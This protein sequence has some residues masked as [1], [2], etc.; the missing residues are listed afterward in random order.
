[1]SA[2]YKSSIERLLLTLAVP[3]MLLFAAQAIAAEEPFVVLTI[4]GDLLGKIDTPSNNN[5]PEYLITTYYKLLSPETHQQL[6]ALR[7]RLVRLIPDYEVAFTAADSAELTEVKEDINSL[8]AEIR[9][10]HTQLFTPEVV[11]ILE[12]AYSHA[13]SSLS[14]E[15]TTE[16]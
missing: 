3:G 10:L 9:M 2:H 1:M 13:F 8:W 7:D 5:A 4:E 14:L 6:E 12:Q 11:T 15:L 16:E